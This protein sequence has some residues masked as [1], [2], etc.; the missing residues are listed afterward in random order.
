MQV[1]RVEKRAQDKA[2]RVWVKHESLAVAD[3]KDLLIRAGTDTKA[4]G[5]AKRPD[6]LRC[7][8]Q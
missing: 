2:R 1:F 5:G 4:T 8:A 7:A 6:H 3:K